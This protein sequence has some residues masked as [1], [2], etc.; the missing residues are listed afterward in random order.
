MR[1]DVSILE[2]VVFVI[3]AASLNQRP[4]AGRSASTKKYQESMLESWTFGRVVVLADRPVMVQ[5]REDVV[6]V[7]RGTELTDLRQ[8]IFFF[9]RVVDVLSPC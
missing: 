3:V 4:R 6:V 8:L 5:D 7:H 1:L 2:S 9:Q